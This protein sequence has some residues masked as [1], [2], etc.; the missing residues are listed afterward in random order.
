MD[1]PLDILRS[2]LRLLGGGLYSGLPSLEPTAL[3]KVNGAFHRSRHENN[4]AECAGGFGVVINGEGANL[5][6]LA[7]LLDCE[8]NMSYDLSIVNTSYEKKCDGT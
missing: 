5:H 4:V 7:P 2:I 6:L 8:S 3:A 1:A